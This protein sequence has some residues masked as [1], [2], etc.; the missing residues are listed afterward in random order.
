VSTKI[1]IIPRIEKDGTP[2]L[3]LPDDP[4]LRPDFIGCYAHVGQHSEASLDYYY[5]S[6]KPDRE[7]ACAALI[8]EY[9]SI[10]PR[11]AELVLKERRPAWRG[12]PMRWASCVLIG[13]VNGTELHVYDTSGDLEL[14]SKLIGVGDSI[15]ATGT[16]IMSQ[17]NGDEGGPGRYLV[18]TP[19]RIPKSLLGA[20]S[21]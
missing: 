20:V 16:V 17:L 3:F 21:T 8:E 5:E 2:I 19:Q 1:T 10:P 14:G 9:R 13:A 11:D 6:T 4:C 15:V 18:N 12:G 7:N